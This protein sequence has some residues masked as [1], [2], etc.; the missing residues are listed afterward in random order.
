MKQTILMLALVFVG[1]QLHAS[2]ECSVLG[3]TK[4]PEEAITSKD[5]K[6]VNFRRILAARNRAVSSLKKTRLDPR[7]EANQ[8]SEENS[9]FTMMIEELEKA[10]IYTVPINLSVAYGC[11]D[12]ALMGTPTKKNNAF[13]EGIVYVCPKSLDDNEA[14]AFNTSVEG[15]LYE[16]FVHE[17]WHLREAKIPGHKYDPIQSEAYAVA[18]SYKTLGVNEGCAYY[19]QYATTPAI[20]NMVESVGETSNPIRCRVDTTALTSAGGLNSSVTSR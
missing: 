17:S 10:K 12:G 13:C 15:S 20:L 11:G 2:E 18:Y 4:V 5:S 7:I 14:Q 19:K 3:L 8:N 6:D 16:S 1:F 9:R